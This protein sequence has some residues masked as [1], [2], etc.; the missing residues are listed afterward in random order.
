MIKANKAYR[1]VNGDAVYIHSVG[2][3]SA[4]GIRGTFLTG[5]NQGLSDNWT[6]DFPHIVSHDPDDEIYSLTEEVI[7]KETHPEYYL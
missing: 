5:R 6:P 4:W 3:F 1:L 7:P 2:E